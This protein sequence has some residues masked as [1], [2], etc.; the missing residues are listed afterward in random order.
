MKIV[1]AGGGPAGL[2]FAISAKLRNREHD[3]TV[4][5]RN[6]AGVTYG[7]GVTFSDPLL[8]SLYRNDPHSAQ[9]IFESPASWANQEV[10]L[11][12]TQR[13]HLGGYG[14][15]IGRKHLLD[16]LV[17]R[18]LDLGVD[19]Q[20]QHEFKDL[21]E[22]AD[23]DLIVACDGAN[24]RVRRLHGDHFRTG[25]EVG[26]NKY[27]WLGTHRIF[28]SFMFAF[29]ETPAGW[30][31]FYSYP[32]SADTTTFIVECSPETWHG[33][34]FDEL[35]PDESLQLLEAIFEHHLEGHRLM[36]SMRDP[37]KVLW[38]NFTRITNTSWYHDNVVLM[39]DAAH[40]THFSIGSG[41]TL[42]MQDAI[43][44]ADS[45]HIHDD[46]NVALKNY[47]QKRRAEIMGLQ[48]AALSSTEWFENV[49]NHVDQPVTQFAYSLWKRRGHCPPW[50]YPLHLATQIST[51]RRLRRTV[52]ALRHKLQSR[53]RTKLV[54][55][56]FPEYRNAEVLA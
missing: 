46:L 17:D 3:I 6:P 33:L 25:A 37:G 39:G 16:I 5:E 12:G 24:S 2:Y 8:D 31:W 53:R 36:N 1:C 20:F 51:L 34:G 32:F 42:A 15:A 4:I 44:L 18:A 56:A 27:I 52:S 26:R 13:A 22:F 38:G 11:R 47:E 19:V 48:G 49:P 55:N 9:K 45:L 28:D 43:G 30:I 14:F 10:H 50:R 35:G 29:E 7:W 21:S 40:T 41:T 54:D 23:A